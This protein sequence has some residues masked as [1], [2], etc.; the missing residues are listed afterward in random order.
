LVR[1][2]FGAVARSLQKFLSIM[3]FGIAMPGMMQF[4]PVHDA[5]DLRTPKSAGR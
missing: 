4:D 3:T 1:G 2:S 5:V